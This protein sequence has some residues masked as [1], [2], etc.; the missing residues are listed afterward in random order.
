MQIILDWDAGKEGCALQ[1]ALCL[2]FTVEYSGEFLGGSGYF[3][4]TCFSEGNF[5]EACA[6]FEWY[7]KLFLGVHFADNFGLRS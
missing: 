4:R 7:I 3:T 6:D 1:D 2:D 5:E